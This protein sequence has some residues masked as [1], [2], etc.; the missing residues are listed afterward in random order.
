MSA[1]PASVVDRTDTWC[2]IGA[3]AHGLPAVKALLERGIPVQGYERESDVGG[4]WN[5]DAASSRVYSSTHLISSKPFTSYPDFPMP[6][7]YPDYPHHRLVLEYFRRYADHFGL[8]PHIAF[9][10]EVE[11][12]E[13]V[14]A[15]AAWDVTVRDAAGGRA[16]SRF[17]GVVVANGHNW[18]PK[19]PEYPGQSSFA[20]QILHSASYKG[21]EVLRGRRVL[22]VG[23]GNTGCDLAVESAQQAA[24]T[25]HSTRRG[26]YYNPKYVN[27]RPSDQIADTLLMLRVPL[28]LRRLGFG[29]TQRL[30]VGDYAKIGLRRP[31]HKFFETHPVVNSLLA[32]YV[33]QGDITPKPDI[34]R[35]DGTGVVFSDGSR[36]EV[37]VVLFCTGYLVRFDFLDAHA[38]LNWR[39]T[40]PHLYL[41]VFTPQHDNLFVSGLIQPDSGQWCLA[42]WQGVLIASYV[43]AR[44]DRPE[45]AARF[46]E[47]VAVH[48]DERFTGGTTYA[49]SSRHY[50]EIAHQEYLEHVEQA[51]NQLEGSVP[52]G[53]R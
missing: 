42:H 13:P 25:W 37:D 45:A 5:A 41:H 31:D 2:V 36:V 29:L 9:G 32:Y 35:F 17:A 18:N 47:Q 50:Y 19:V 7:E 44:R 27:G 48:A 28:A 33:G 3:G 49:E 43:E 11:S 51:I 52:V 20:G 26:Y 38:H 6:D 40:H 4:N 39:D 21:P 10:T 15:G 14:G 46:R 23:A 12:V 30:V 8:R 34:D 1:V 24:A 22:V 53:S 16:T